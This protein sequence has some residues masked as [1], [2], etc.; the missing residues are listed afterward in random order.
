MALNFRRPCT[1]ILLA[2]ACGGTTEPADGTAAGTDAPTTSE[3]PTDTEG[4]P[5]DTDP[6][7]ATVTYHRDVRPIVERHCV[8]CHSEGNIGPFQ[9]TTYDEVHTYRDIALATIDGNT[10]PP[11]GIEDDC[12]DFVADPSLSTEDKTVFAQW[13]EQG[14][15]EGDSAD[16]V[17]PAPLDRPELSRTDLTLQLPEPYEPQI[18]PDDYRCFVLDWPQTETTFI[19]GYQFEADNTSITHHAIVYVVGPE[20]AAEYDALDEAEP[21]PG[22]TCFGGPGGSQAFDF[23]RSRWLG[24]W[25]PGTRVGD[26][27]E[28]TGLRV[29]PGSRIIIQMHYNTLASNGEPD[30]SILHY[31][32]DDSVEREAFM[33][34]WADPSWLSGG[35]TIPA[36][37]DDTVHSFKTDPTSVIDFMTDIIPANHPIE[38]F[39]TMHHMHRRGS[40]GYQAIVR[41]D[42]S[43]ECLVDLPRFDYAWQ[44][45]Y[46]Y[47]SSRILNPGDELMLECQW[48]NADNAQAVGWGDGTDDEMCLAVHYVTAAR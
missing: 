2:M 17:A 44:T 47:A 36:G 24:A 34:P 35:M 31:K 5:G 33:M 9:L 38:I 6:A 45:F 32:L 46:T 18:A 19:T 20:D 11:W 30:Q 29:E 28:G 13:I 42:G 7:S 48:D 27:P 10:M 22:Y 23:I 8:S 43:T 37:S 3:E 12:G 41:A 15:P 16:Y 26:L 21:G 39:S 14:A 40:R 4:E 1:S 25:A